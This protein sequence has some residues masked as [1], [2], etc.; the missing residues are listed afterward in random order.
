[1]QANQDDRWK[2]LRLIFG[3][4]FFVLVLIEKSMGYDPTTSTL[5]FPTQSFKNIG[6][7]KPEITKGDPFLSPDWEDD[8]SWEEEVYEHSLQKEK[9]KKSLSFED[10]IPQITLPEDRFPGGGK[11]IE[12]ESGWIPLYFLKFYGSGK[13]SQSQLVKLSREF[14]GGDPVSFVLQ[15]LTKGPNPE[16]KT[17]GV[18]SAIPKRIKMDPVYR[19]DQGVL[20]LS[21]SEEITIGGSHEILKDRLDQLVFSLVGNYGISGVILYTNGERLRSFG[22]DGLGLPSVL[23]RNQRKVLVF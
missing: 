20:H 2:S 19:I 5:K 4:L 22:S 18:I 11:K 7:T 8:L 13:N 15:E 10:E 1:M 12:A 9:S 16:E 6:K 17:K 14:P 3:G 21:L 23:V